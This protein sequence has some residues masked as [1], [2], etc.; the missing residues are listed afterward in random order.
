[1]ETFYAQIIGAEPRLTKETARLAGSEFLF[2]NKK[3]KNLL[4]F[5][6]QPIDKTLQRCCRYYID[7][8]ET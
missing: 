7:E 3:I 5:E 2:E 6:F 1:M 4:N 8:S